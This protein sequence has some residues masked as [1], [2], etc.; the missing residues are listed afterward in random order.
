MGIF[1][2]KKA[3]ALK[4]SIADYLKISQISQ[5]AY[6]IIAPSCIYVNGKAI[7]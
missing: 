4:S 3:I 5:L 2:V 6:M 7:F 1:C